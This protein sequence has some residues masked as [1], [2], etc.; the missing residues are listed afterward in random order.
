LGLKTLESEIMKNDNLYRIIS[1][2]IKSINLIF[3]KFKSIKE[4]P[5]NTENRIEKLKDFDYHLNNFKKLNVNNMRRYDN[6]TSLTLK[7]EYSEEFSDIVSP[8]KTDDV[9]NVLLVGLGSNK[10]DEKSLNSQSI[11]ESISAFSASKIESEKSKVKN[12]K[13]I[14]NKKLQSSVSEFELNEGL[15]PI[16]KNSKLKSWNKELKPMKTKTKFSININ[17]YST[18]SPRN[19]LKSGI[20]TANTQSSNFTNSYNNDH[21]AKRN[22]NHTPINGNTVQK[23][24]SQSALIN[25]DL[26]NLPPRKLSEDFGK[27]IKKAEINNNQSQN[28]HF[29]KD[30]NDRA[31]VHSP[32]NYVE[33]I[34]VALSLIKNNTFSPSTSSQSKFNMIFRS[35][36]IPATS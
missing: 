20:V 19:V 11:K 12:A 8:I 29:R 35:Y 36:S 15:K 32:N 6:M 21:K 33:R 16:K 22:Q 17:K 28:G 5:P 9:E 4:M 14:K 30:S 24:K 1:K 25:S 26:K 3:E 7:S 10:A 23:T 13:H 2:Y 34:D 18:N 27:Q 31:R